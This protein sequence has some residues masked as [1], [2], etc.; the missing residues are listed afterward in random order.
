MLPRITHDVPTY[1][2]TRISPNAFRLARSRD[3]L[4]YLSKGQI[5]ALA[6]SSV[7]MELF[8]RTEA[9]APRG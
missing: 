8:H 9:E 3:M 6:A 1:A 2:D 7:T 4:D 5:S